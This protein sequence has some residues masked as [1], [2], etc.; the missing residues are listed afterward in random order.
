MAWSVVSARASVGRGEGSASGE[1]HSGDAGMPMG[2]RSSSA[3]L[4]AFVSG[5]AFQVGRARLRPAGRSPG[6]HR[7]AAPR[8][9]DP[10]HVPV[11]EG[12]GVGDR[13]HQV[14]TEAGIHATQL[15]LAP[16]DEQPAPGLAATKREV[17]ADHHPPIWSRSRRRNSGTTTTGPSLGQSAQW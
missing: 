11:R 12:K 3:R 14:V 13:H 8:P 10:S 6:C 15:A 2:V 7:S 4:R 16:L 5:P 9:L 17:E 1:A